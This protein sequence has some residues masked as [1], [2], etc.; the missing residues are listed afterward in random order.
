[1]HKPVWG[2]LAV[3]TSSNSPFCVPCICSV[4]NGEVLI[5]IDDNTRSHTTD[6]DTRTVTSLKWIRLMDRT[7]VIS[8]SVQKLSLILFCIGANP[9]ETRDGVL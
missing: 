1:M 2:S 6:R 5:N 3:L 4:Q 7:Q 9:H 8:D